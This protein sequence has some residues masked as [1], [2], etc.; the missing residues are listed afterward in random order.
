MD[1]AI[2]ASAAA[3]PPAPAATPTIEAPVILTPPAAPAAAPMMATGGEVAASGEAINWFMVGLFA[4]AMAAGIYSII[5]HKKKVEN[6]HKLKV[7][8]TGQ[9]KELKERVNRLSNP[10]RKTS[11]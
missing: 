2:L 8:L 3:T 4:V 11:A 9:M 10:Q 6:D 5:A 1:S 7:D